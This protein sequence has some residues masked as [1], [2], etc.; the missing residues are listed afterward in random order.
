MTY[1]QGFGRALNM[2]LAKELS[3]Q[4]DE[5]QGESVQSVSDGWIRQA[6]QMNE[7]AETAD[8]RMALFLLRSQGLILNA[9]LIMGPPEL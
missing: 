4:V 7:L 8:D 3:V 5:G 1:S 2:W 6:A 9:L